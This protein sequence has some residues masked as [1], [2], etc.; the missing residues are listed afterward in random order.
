[1]YQGQPGILRC[2]QASSKLKDRA[3][4]QAGKSHNFFEIKLRMKKYIFLIIT[5]KF[6]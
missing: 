1:M 5:Y 6:L 2:L 3:S 4:K